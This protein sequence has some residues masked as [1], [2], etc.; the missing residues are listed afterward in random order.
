[1]VDGINFKQLLAQFDT[2]K[3]GKINK[4]EAEKIGFLPFKVEGDLTEEVFNMKIK[5][6]SVEESEKEPATLKQSVKNTL[7]PCCTFPYEVPIKK[8]SSLEEIPVGTHGGIRDALFTDISSL[9]LTKEQLL[10]L[11]IDD[12]TVLSNEQKAMLKDS[13]EN[14]KNPGL[15]IRDLHE[16]GITGKGVK[17]AIVD[18]SL[19]P[20]NEY[21]DRIV[22]Y[23]EH[24]KEEKPDFFK[25]G[26]FHG[27]SVTSIAVGE[28]VGVAPDADVVYFAATTDNKNYAEA[29]NRVVELNKKLP[30][31]EKIPVISISWGFNPNGDDYNLIQEAVQ[32]AKENGVYIVYSGSDI[33]GANRNPQADA[34]N[35][36]NYTMGAFLTDRYESRYK[37]ALEKNPDITPEDIYDG[38]YARE[39]LLVPMDHR[40]VA[41]LKSEDGYRFDGND[42]GM[43]WAVPWYAGMYALAKQVRP[44]ITPE[45]FEKAALDTATECRVKDGVFKGKLAGML[46]NPKALIENITSE[47]QD[48]N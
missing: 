15:G 31:N 4:Q 32:N 30:D 16:Q 14:M 35:P 44:D 20:H 17:I 22:F 19:S 12:T 9:K 33:L 39:Y 45:E 25:E 26:S 29:I 43:S 13:F 3:D 34:D 8:V 48:S 37:D 18:Q 2:N 24:G 42:G 46:I 7:P 36:E 23:E 21:S 6:L 10:D 5:G 47:K 1:M 41:D 27:P 11:C 40:T 38:D 28:N